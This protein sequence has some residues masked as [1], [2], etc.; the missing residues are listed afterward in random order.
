MASPAARYE[1][2]F[3]RQPIPDHELDAPP[4]CGSM[5]PD[6]VQ[7]AMRPP[8]VPT[9]HWSRIHV[10]DSA[11]VDPIVGTITLPLPQ[12]LHYDS[13]RSRELARLMAHPVQKQTMLAPGWSASSLESPEPL[14]YMGAS[15]CADRVVTPWYGVV[16]CLLT[17]ELQTR[18]FAV[19]DLELIE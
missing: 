16:V 1:M 17:L 12:L 14:L 5:H 2:C 19:A 3:S 15:V 11:S 6:A 18:L 7:G 4:L 9:P 8:H 13:V 10:L